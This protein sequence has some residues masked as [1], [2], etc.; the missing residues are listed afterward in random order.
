MNPLLGSQ[1]QIVFNESLSTKQE[2]ISLSCVII[3]A[4]LSGSD[5]TM[6]LVLVSVSIKIDHFNE[7]LKVQKWLVLFGFK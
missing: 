2:T 3:T 1:V 7:V 6:R 5:I 4:L